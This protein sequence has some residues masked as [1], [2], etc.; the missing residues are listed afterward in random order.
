MYDIPFKF[1]NIPFIVVIYELK[2][3]ILLRDYVVIDNLGNIKI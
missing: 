2:Q 3:Y 1:I